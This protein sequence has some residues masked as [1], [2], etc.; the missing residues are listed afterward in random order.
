MRLGDEWSDLIK[1]VNPQTY[2]QPAAPDA[3]DT[4][5]ARKGAEFSPAKFPLGPAAEP[6]Q[7]LEIVAKRPSKPALSSSRFL[8]GV[9]VALFLVKL[10]SERTSK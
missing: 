10:I 5:L 2:E 9:L 3:W 8:V 6:N 7:R 4:I 1:A